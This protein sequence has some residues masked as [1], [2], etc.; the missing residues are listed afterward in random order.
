MS[1]VLRAV[2]L[3]SLKVRVVGCRHRHVVAYRVATDNKSASVD[4]SSANRSLQHLCVFHRVGY[5][6][7]GRCLSLLQFTHGFDGIH[8]IHLR[9][10]SVYVWQTVGDSLT[11]CIR[12]SQRHILYSGHILDRVLG[13]H[14]CVGDDVCA[15][16]VSV[17]IHYPLQHLSATVVIE[18]GIDIR[19]RDTVGVK[20]T[21]KQ[22]VV[23]QRVDLGDTQAIGYHRACSRSTT[24]TNHHSQ[25]VA[26][27]VDKVLHYEEVSW[28]THCLHDV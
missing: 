2:G 24:R 18:V 5:A 7:V 25:F 4:T 27:R 6:W 15:V 1:V 12:Y 3:G 10:L 26:G 11:Q 22:Q 13:G 19:Q 23:L 8:Q 9:R 17:L 20:E 14:R 28:E 16:L 21:L